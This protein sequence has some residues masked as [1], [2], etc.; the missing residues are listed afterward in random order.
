MDCRLLAKVWI[1]VSV[2][3]LTGALNSAV[4]AQSA[5]PALKILLPQDEEI[6]TIGQEILVR[7]EVTGNV[8]EIFVSC[9][10]MLCFGKAH[11]TIVPYYPNIFRLTIPGG[12]GARRIR[13]GGTTSNG[14]MILS[15]QIKLLAVPPTA[16]I[17]VFE[18]L[19][20]TIE[21][22]FVGAEQ[23]LS[24][25]HK[26]SASAT[27]EDITGLTDGRFFL[28]VRFQDAGIAE[29]TQE[30]RVRAVRAGETLMLVSV[31]YSPPARIIP[32][33]IVVKQSRQGDVNADGE[34]DSKDIAMFN[35]WIGS[36]VVV[37]E[38]ARDLNRDGKID[39]LDSRIAVTL[40]TRPRCA[41]Q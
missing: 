21:L 38:D 1:A 7:V 36:P 34:V 9:D 17:G 16:L 33:Q 10:E 41:I 32:V 19:P 37:S 22:P 31:G 23:P 18:V 28:N 27:P 14:V 40:C 2:F 15:P 5:V 24:I 30:R 4:Q 39:A 26:A 3:T 12:V 35:F 11:T 13:A 29:F 6:V 25:T 8:S 20:N